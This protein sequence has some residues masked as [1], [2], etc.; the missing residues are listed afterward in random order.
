MLLHRADLQDIAV[1]SYQQLLL[2]AMGFFTTFQA[3]DELHLLP[4]WCS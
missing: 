3:A 4:V 1:F 2:R